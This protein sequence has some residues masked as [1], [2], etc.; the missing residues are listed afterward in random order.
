[1]SHVSELINT[2]RSRVFFEE[3]SGPGGG[4]VHENLW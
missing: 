1:M 2:V 3:L 4:C